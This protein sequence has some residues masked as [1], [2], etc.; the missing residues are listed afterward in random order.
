MVFFPFTVPTKQP[1]KPPRP[2][3]PSKPKVTQ[4]SPK[5]L[6]SDKEDKIATQSCSN[7]KNCS[8][9]GTTVLPDTTGLTPT[10]PPVPRP[11]ATPVPRP[12]TTVKQNPTNQVNVPPLIKLHESWDVGLVTPVENSNVPTSNYL[13][14]LLDVFISEP[15]YEL[16]NLVNI[17]GKKTGQS[18]ENHSENMTALHSD[19]NIRAKIQAFE[20][21][22]GAENVEN[23]ETPAPLPR[24]RKAHPKPPVLA[25]KPSIAPRPSMRKPKEE[26]IPQD[27]H[28]NDVIIPPTPAPRPQLFKKPLDTKDESDFQLPLRTIP[29][30]PSR[31]SLIK[32]KN[33]SSQDEEVVF[34]GLPSPLKPSKDLLN[35]NN[36]NSTAL[37]P[38]TTSIESMHTNDYVDAAISKCQC[39][40]GPQCDAKPCSS[41]NYFSGFSR[42]I[43]PLQ[44]TLLLNPHVKGDSVTRHQ[45][46]RE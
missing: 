32:V 27:N 39:F 37:L 4:T 24:P 26:E 14:E 38:N 33:V 2:L 12:R 29:I 19:R 15:Q 1:N 28:L 17:Q 11:R 35:F 13:N 16:S 45:I 21:V 22:F 8:S 42:C 36:H 7:A 18:A 6:C 41:Y 43:H 5:E 30:P 46:F 44:I 9:P 23:D 40:S 3:L 10:Q 25:P 31:P 34:K 20:S